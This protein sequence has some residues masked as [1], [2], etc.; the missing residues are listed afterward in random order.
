MKIHP[1]LGFIAAALM[2]PAH[3]Q[4]SGT[5][6]ARDAL[7]K[8]EGDTDQTTLLKQTLTAVDKQYSLIKRGKLAATYD[9][10]YS[11]IGQEKI[12][13]DITN[14]NLTLFN[15]ENDSSHTITNTVSVDYG[16][17]D[18]LTASVVLPLVSKYSENPAFSGMSHS[19]GD[20]GVGARY[21]PFGVQRGRPS[22]TVNSTLRLPTGKSPFKVDA[23]QD[24][25]TGSGVPQLSA[26]VAVNHIVDPVALFGS[27]NLTYSGA[28]KD[29]N[30]IRGTRVLTRVEPG[31]AFGFGVGFAYALS[32]GIT[33]SVSIQ[34]SIAR[35][36]KLYFRDGTVSRTK[37]QTSGVLNLGLGVRVSPKTTI[38]ITAGIGLTENSPDFTLG[39]S[40]PLSF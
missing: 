8:Q 38:N 35:G 40:M 19:I 16:V 11:Y 30:Q 34:E 36:T 28:A 25:A 13:A 1:L 29:L 26:G 32:Y 17:R 10:S 12:N 27:V 7:K 31:M 33:T 3:A 18:N 14:G 37:T 5:D 9:F 6:A 23:N 20:I 21:Q 2:L 4:Q 22:L 24:L 39:L 15:I